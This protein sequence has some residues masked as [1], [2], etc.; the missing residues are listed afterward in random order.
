VWLDG[1]GPFGMVQISYSLEIV[2]L[3][4][5][6]VILD[7]HGKFSPKKNKFSTTFSVITGRQT[8]ID[9]PIITI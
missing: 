3:V 4:V 9:D 8:R 6:L 1:C 7:R 2:T 5:R